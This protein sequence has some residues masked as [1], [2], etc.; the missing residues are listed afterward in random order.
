MP[1]LTDVLIAMI[2]LYTVTGIITVLFLGVIITGTVRAHLNPDRYGPR[3]DSNG[4]RQSRARGIARAVVETLPIVKFGDQED[5]QPPKSDVEMASNDGEDRDSTDGSSAGTER[6]TEAVNTSLATTTTPAE[7]ATN[8]ATAAATT[9][10]SNETK[11][12]NN[13]DDDDIQTEERGKDQ[14]DP[15]VAENASGPSRAS[16]T[17]IGPSSPTVEN[18]AANAETSDAGTLVCPICTDDFIKGQDVRLLPCKHKF[19]PECVDPWLLNVSGTC[20]LW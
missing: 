14:Q 8:T 12:C 11:S 2:I 3:Q 6:Q 15:I 20:P 5:K 10:P 4:Q 13:N 18:T 17:N 16:D 7:T 9:A 1:V 19:H